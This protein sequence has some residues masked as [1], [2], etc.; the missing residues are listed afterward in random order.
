MV[1]CIA[2]NNPRAQHEV[3]HLSSREEKLRLTFDRPDARLSFL[4]YTP[5]ARLPRPLERTAL[6]RMTMERGATCRTS[7]GEAEAISRTRL[8]ASLTLATRS[9]ADGCAQVGRQPPGQIDVKV[10]S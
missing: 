2:R 6:A 9:L 4:G 7:L 8:R 10:T 1:A 5:R 3:S